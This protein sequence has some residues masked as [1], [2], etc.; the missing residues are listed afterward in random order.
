MWIRSTRWKPVVLFRP[1]DVVHTIELLLWDLPRCSNL[2]QIAP[3]F[4]THQGSWDKVGTVVLILKFKFFLWTYWQDDIIWSC[5]SYYCI[6][7]PVSFET[8]DL[9]FPG[10]NCWLEVRNSQ[11]EILAG[12]VFISS[13]GAFSGLS[14]SLWRTREPAFIMHLWNTCIAISHFFKRKKCRL[15]NFGIAALKIRCSHCGFAKPWFLCHAFADYR[16][17]FKLRDPRS[18]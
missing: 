3:V 6:L 8:C 7:R 11:L 2:L 1:E 4:K 12:A 18:A 16:Y 15:S 9:R 10:L 14:S 13:L 17:Y 5:M